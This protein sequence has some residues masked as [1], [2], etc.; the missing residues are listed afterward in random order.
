MSKSTILIAIFGTLSLLSTIGFAWSAYENAQ[1][2]LHHCY[3]YK[4]S[5]GMVLHCA[6]EDF[7]ITMAPDHAPSRPITH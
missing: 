3:G 7:Y 6:D 4:D 2:R 1:V 5:V